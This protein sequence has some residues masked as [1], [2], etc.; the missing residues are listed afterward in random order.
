M[1]VARPCVLC[2]IHPGNSRGIRIYSYS[3]LRSVYV[4]EAPGRTRTKSFGTIALCDRCL[5]EYARGAVTVRDDRAA[6]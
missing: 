2:S 6:V 1:S 3:L 4:R 5:E